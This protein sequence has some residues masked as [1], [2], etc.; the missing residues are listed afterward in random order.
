MRIGYARVSTQD[1]NLDSQKDAL[2]KANCVVIYREK[3]SGKNLE[4]P[5]LK[6]IMDDIGEGDVLVVVKLD[7]LGRS[8]RD[9]IDLVNK[10]HEKKVA[11]VSLN[12]NIDTST[13]TG[14]LIFHVFG[15]LAEFE[16]ELIRE[17]TNAGLAAARARGRKG[18]KPKGLTKEAISKATTVKFLYDQ[19]VKTVDEIAKDLNISRATCYRYLE[20]ANTEEAKVAAAK[21]AAAEKVAAAVLSKK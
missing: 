9:L 1:Q 18:G 2:K 10:L 12:E 19:R 11:F 21:K 20:Y 17:R 16:R 13:P 14:K 15:A 4:R 3:A 8:L 6:R 5:E 7:R